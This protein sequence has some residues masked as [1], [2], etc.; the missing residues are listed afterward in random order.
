MPELPADEAKLELP[1]REALARH[2]ENAACATCHQ[3]FDSLGVAF[4]GFGPIGERRLKDLGGRPIE[5]KAV[6]PSGSEGSGLA[7]LQN[8][9]RTEREQEFLENLCRKLLSY[10]L[11]RTLLPSDDSTVAAMRR[12]LAG[13]GNR[14]SGLL[15]EIVTS[16]QFLNKRGE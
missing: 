1:L 4:E 3:R 8:Y 12:R 11:G 16:R 7:G 6:F 5:T 15:E 2:R 13:D 10:A 9:L 14:L